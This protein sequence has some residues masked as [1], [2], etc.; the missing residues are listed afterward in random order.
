MVCVCVSQGNKG[1]LVQA[2]ATGTL[3]SLSLIVNLYPGTVGGAVTPPHPCGFLRN[4]FVDL[5]CC[6]TSSLNINR[7]EH[8]SIFSFYT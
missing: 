6:P 4:I 7:Q 2:S 5:S 8:L 1:G 3:S